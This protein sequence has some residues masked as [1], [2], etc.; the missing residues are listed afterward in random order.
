MFLTL[1]AELR[2]ATTNAAGI[3]LN[4]VSMMYV[5]LSVNVNDKRSHLCGSFR[6]GGLPRGGDLA[7]F[8]YL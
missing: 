1:V 3:W 2:S 8:R 5:I 6:W 4:S 7:G